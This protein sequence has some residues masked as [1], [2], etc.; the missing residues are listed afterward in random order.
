MEKNAGNGEERNVTRPR[1]HS[2]RTGSF[3]LQ[4][5]HGLHGSQRSGLLGN[6]DAGRKGGLGFILNALVPDHSH[7]AAPLP[8]RDSRLPS[9]FT[10][11]SKA[12][13]GLCRAHYSPSVRL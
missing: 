12:R 6:K 2:K 9:T 1:P 13:G 7:W 10:P 11:A 8:F 3:R 5:L 4:F